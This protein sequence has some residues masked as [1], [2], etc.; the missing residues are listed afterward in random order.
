MTAGKN[1]NI[2]TKRFTAKKGGSC[3]AVGSTVASNMKRYVTFISVRQ[4]SLARGAGSKLWFCSAAASQSINTTALASVANKFTVR[5]ASAF[6]AD[7]VF[8]YPRSGPDPEN[9]LFS[10]AASKLLSVRMTA[11]SQAGSASCTVFVQYYDQ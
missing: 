5:L 1:Y 8:M 10:I 3:V 9:P 2:Q 7:K 6:G 4:N 11:T